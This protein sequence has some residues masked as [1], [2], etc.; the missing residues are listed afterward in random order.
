MTKRLK[1]KK[2]KEIILKPVRPN[3]GI[4]AAYY[5]ALHALIKQMCEEAQDKI[6]NAYEDSPPLMAGD[7]LPSAI[8]IAIIKSL[9]K[10]WHK[11]FDS[12]AQKLAEYYSQKIADRSDHVL[13]T[14]LDESG[15]SVKFTNTL[16]IQ[17]ALD[18]TIGEQVSLIRSIPQQY[19][20]Q[21]E[22]LVMRSV[23]AGRDL[24]WLSENLRKRYRVTKRRAALIAR[25][26][27]N[28]ATAVITRVRQAELGITEALWLHSHGGKEPRRSHLANNRKRY[29]I[30]TGWYDPDEKEFIWPGTLIN[31]R[32]NCASIIPALDD[33]RYG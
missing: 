16:E 4:R 6:L 21:I 26:Q 1:P 7:K 17:D 18:A 14:V 20:S 15:F 24:A 23:T 9:V 8:Q 3:E 12:A 2:N 31:C 30:A 10:R 32:C 33:G 29:M 28:K 13:K 22:G 11:R 25:D 19:F 5:K 27:N